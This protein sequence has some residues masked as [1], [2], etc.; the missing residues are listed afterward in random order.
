M[1]KYRNLLNVNTPLASNECT[2]IFNNHTFDSQ[3]R[4]IVTQPSLQV[5]V[6]VNTSLLTELGTH[7][8][9]LDHPSAITC[10]KDEGVL[11]VVFYPDEVTEETKEYVDNSLRR[12]KQLVNEH[13]DWV[14]HIVWP[15]NSEIADKANLSLPNNAYIYNGATNETD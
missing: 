7:F 4:L 1:A 6:D 11:A 8:K 12:V 15:E 10:R 13:V 14:F 2:V 5:L 9:E 3:G